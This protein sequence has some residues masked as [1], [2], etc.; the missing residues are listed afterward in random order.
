MLALTHANS[1]DNLSV[2]S[3]HYR[4]LSHFLGLTGSDGKLHRGVPTVNVL[5]CLDLLSPVT[6]PSSETEFSF[7]SQSGRKKLTAARYVEIIEQLRPSL[8]IQPFP[9]VTA[10]S[11]KK[12]TGKS[13]SHTTVFARDCLKQLQV[14]GADQ[15][16]A[17]SSF[18]PA[19]GG[20][21]DPKARH[22]SLQDFQT[23]YE[24]YSNL[25]GGVFLSGF[26]VG[27]TADQRTTLLRQIVVS[28]KS[29]KRQLVI[30]SSM[31]FQESLPPQLPRFLSGLGDPGK[32]IYQSRS[33]Y[34]IVNPH[35][36]G[37]FMC[38][39]G[40]GG[41]VHIRVSLRYC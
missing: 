41:F 14:K 7:D 29:K 27:E 15:P 30:F 37:D 2:I 28:Q 21:I 3:S 38:G 22:L 35:F 5:S 8:A 4:D 23:T 34:Q 11:Q 10:F 12:R 40:R 25:I 32:K 19:I 6:L 31:S 18:W 26:G 13:V 17:F 24:Q 16:E 9:E 36:S 1:Y 33:R 20:G 39:G